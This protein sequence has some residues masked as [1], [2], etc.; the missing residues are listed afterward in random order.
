VPRSPFPREIDTRRLTKGSGWGY[1]LTRT[2]FDPP[3]IARMAD[4]VVSFRNIPGGGDVDERV[5]GR[6]P[7]N[8][9]KEIPVSNTERRIV[10]F[11]EWPV[12]RLLDPRN[13]HG[14][15]GR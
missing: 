15:P 1:I 7:V 9:R 5:S 3:P 11:G 13:V 12:W 4:W 10:H 6:P 2:F 14:H 8:P